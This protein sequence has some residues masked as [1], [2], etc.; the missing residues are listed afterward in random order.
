MTNSADANAPFT[1]SRHQGEVRKHISASLDWNNATLVGRTV[2]IDRPREELFEFWKHLSN[3]ATF[4]ENIQRI[5]VIGEKRSHWV[6]FGPNDRPIE[7]DAEIVEERAGELLAWRSLEGADVK[8]AGQIVFSDAPGGR[9]T[10]VSAIIAYEA[11]GGEVG[12]LVAK[13][14]GADPKVQ[15]HRDLRRFKQLMETGEVSTTEPPFAAPRG[16]H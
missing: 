12:K 1:A 13:L 6:V 16:G 2:T 14:M 4:M 5:D 11:P 10:Q 8:N 7:W 9:G 3:L 15:T